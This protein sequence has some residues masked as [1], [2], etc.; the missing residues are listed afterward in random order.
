MAIL[1]AGVDEAGRGPLAGPVI[2]SAV[3]LKPQHT[4]V[5][6]K[7]SKQLSAHRREQLAEKIRSEALAWS[8]GK[9]SV[10]EIDAYNIGQATLLAMKRAV[11]ALSIVPDEVFIDGK[12]KPILKIT[13]QTFVKGDQLYPVISAASILAKVFRDECMKQLDQQYPAYGFA[14][15]KGYGTAQHLRALKRYGYTKVHRYSFRPV[16]ES[17]QHT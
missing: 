9:A 14:Q 16:R 10:H 7:D 8:I 4:I 11:E 6:L 1:I 12:Q 15:H 13:T 5:G 2:A 17:H 3:I